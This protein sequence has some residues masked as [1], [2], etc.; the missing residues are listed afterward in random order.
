MYT[1]HVCGVLEALERSLGHLGAVLDVS[2][3]L[4]EPLWWHLK[5]S[6]S[7]LGGVWEALGTILGA[8]WEPKGRPRSQSLPKAS[9]R[10]PGT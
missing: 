10:A 6:W 3:G 2:W 5:R 1:G 8:S 7:C 4:L 9:G